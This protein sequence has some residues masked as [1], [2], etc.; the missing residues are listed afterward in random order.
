M[1]NQLRD[2]IDECISELMDD[3]F[4]SS[5]DEVFYVHLAKRINKFTATATEESN[6]NLMR[7]KHRVNNKKLTFKERAKAIDTFSKVATGV[8]T[9][10]LGFLSRVI[11]DHFSSG[12]DI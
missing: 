4:N 3:K 9:T 2:L 12:G 11:M 1:S 10:Y 5:K 7:M 8:S 6:Y